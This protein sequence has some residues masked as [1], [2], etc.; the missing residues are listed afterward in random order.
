MIIDA[1]NENALDVFT[2]RTRMP[3]SEQL[4]SYVRLFRA[5]AGELRRAAFGFFP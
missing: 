5:A 2:T 1:D 3:H 4:P